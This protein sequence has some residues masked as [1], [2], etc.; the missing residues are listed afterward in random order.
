[1]VGVG[2]FMQLIEYNVHGTTFIS[3]KL[4]LPCNGPSIE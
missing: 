4:H 2:Y 3:V 1:M